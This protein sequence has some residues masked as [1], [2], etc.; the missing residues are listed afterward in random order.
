MEIRK[1]ERIYDEFNADGRWTVI[2]NGEAVS[3][4]GVNTRASRYMGSYIKT[5]LVGGVGTPVEYRRRGYVR[6]IFDNIGAVAQEKGWAVSMLHPFSF[7]YYRKFGYEKISDHLIIE[8]PMTALAPF[9]RVDFVPLKTPEQQR[10]LSECYEAFAADKNIMFR[11][12]ADNF[13]LD[14]GSGKRYYLHTDGEG[15]CDAFVE[16]QVENVFYVNHMQSVNLNVYEFAYTS[17]AGLT[18]MLGFLRMY[19]GQLESVKIHNAA[20]APE[21]DMALRN[22]THTKYT[23][24]PDIMAR[25]F[26]LPAMMEHRIWPKEHGVFTLRT[27]DTLPYMNACWQVEYEGGKCEVIRLPD[28]SAADLTM[29]SPALSQFVYGYSEYTARNISYLPGVILDNAESDIFK[30]FHKQNNGLFEHF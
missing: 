28:G 5:M 16:T 7:Q 30:V 15:K 19:E 22:Y 21:L 18:A 4:G 25:I 10:M 24:V 23:L 3:S 13:S 2:E 9:D 11:R 1:D 27:V 8:F 6:R 12:T 20:M 29:P 26:D 14:P 17:P